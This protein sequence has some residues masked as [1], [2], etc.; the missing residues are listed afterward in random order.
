MSKKNKKKLSPYQQKKL[1]E[2]EEQ[3]NN[4]KKYKNPTNSVAGK[5][6]IFILS[7]LMLGSGL[8]ALIYAII[9]NYVK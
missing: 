7:I 9:Q 2:L 1:A 8:F 6:I 4:K 3:E 5:I